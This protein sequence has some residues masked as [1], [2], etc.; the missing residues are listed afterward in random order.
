LNISSHEAQSH[1]AWLNAR[2][3][4]R[5]LE[6]SRMEAAALRRRLTSIAENPAGTSDVLSKYYYYF[7]Y[8]CLGDESSI[9]ILFIFIFF[10]LT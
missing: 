6:E 4:E 8:Y 3:A 9:I 5:R 1:T 10:S 2:Q 7:Y